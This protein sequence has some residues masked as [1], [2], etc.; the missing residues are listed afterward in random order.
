MLNYNLNI[1]S[2]LQQEKKNSDVR[3]D[4][5]W[6][7]HSFAS[8]SDSS[9]IPELGFATMSINAVNTNCIQISNDN[10]GFFQT[11]AQSQVTAS[12]TGSKWPITG[13]VT[14]SLNT[15][16]ISYDPVTPNQF[17]GAAIS[18]SAAAIIANPSITGSILTNR[19]IAIDFIRYYVSSSIIHQKGN[20]YNPKVNYKVNVTSPS[21][22]YV[23][24]SFLIQKDT[25]NVPVVTQIYASASN[26]GS[27]NYEYAVNM[28]ASLSGAADYWNSA[29]NFKEYTMSLSIPEISYYAESYKTNGNLTAS[30]I[31]S[32]NNP[33][34]ITASIELKPWTPFA[35]EVIAVGAGGA[36]GGSNN[37]LYSGGGG[38]AGAVVSASW[39]IPV[40]T[41]FDIT[42]GAGGTCPTGNFSG[43]AG[44]DTTIYWPDVSSNILIAKGGSGG[45][46]VGI[47]SADGGS[48]GGTVGGPGGTTGGV[49][50]NTFPANSTQAL[51][52][53]GNKGSTGHEHRSDIPIPFSLLGGGGGGVTSAGQRGSS[54]NGGTGGLGI[55][56]TSY[57]AG[58]FVAVGGDGGSYNIPPLKQT[59]GADTANS[60]SG[61]FGANGGD[62]PSISVRGGNG[63]NG[64]VIIR[65]RG[66][67]SATGGNTITT[68][69]GYTTHIFTT[70]G[71]FNP[72]ANYKCC[73]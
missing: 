32:D 55:N 73:L 17:Y 69:G 21:A 49:L 65:Y 71:T 56:L 37:R 50:T 53:T 23:S 64:I 22:S 61:G 13:S 18:A 10:G 45:A 44:G 62:N 41:S 11:A 34:N 39:L 2:P 67:Q 51:S 40:L 31:A 26:I 30:F 42:I 60:G 47:A 3:P 14:M 38:G 70:N 19:F 25:P 57:G 52:P 59:N 27:V 20:I 7:F 36:G 15:F 35:V 1:N 28:S 8:A 4:I 16:G 54:Y 33:Y 43:S 72:T 29:S 5:R 46:N 6:D 63:G 12:L 68:A 48:T 66:S 24:A 9:N 58:A